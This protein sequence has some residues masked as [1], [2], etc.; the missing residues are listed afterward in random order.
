MYRGVPE[1]DVERSLERAAY[2]LERKGLAMAALSD[3]SCPAASVRTRRASF[4]GRLGGLNQSFNISQATS[5]AYRRGA[6]RR[7]RQWARVLSHA[8]LRAGITGAFADLQVSSVVSAPDSPSNS[9][10]MARAI[11]CMTRSLPFLLVGQPSSFDS[12]GREV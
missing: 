12:L 7:P 9:R 5:S 6:S 11:E 1:F 10:M 3:D 4:S 2:T 8:A